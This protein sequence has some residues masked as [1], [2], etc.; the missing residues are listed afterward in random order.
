MSKKRFKLCLYLL[1]GFF[2]LTQF[3]PPV[4]SLTIEEKKAS[5]L[6]E[7]DQKELHFFLV[8]LNKNLRNLKEQLQEKYELVNQY[9][10]DQESDEA[11]QILLKEVNE[12]RFEMIDLEKKW[13]DL[14][15]SEGKNDDEGYALWDQDEISLSHLVMEYGSSDYLYVIPPEMITMKL[16]MHS[17]LPIPRES[18]SELLE[19]ILLQSGIGIKQLGPFTR[20]LY[21]LK[22]DLIA[23]DRIISKKADLVK[24]PNK[25]RVVYIFS[26]LPERIGGVCQFFERFRDPKT[27]FV[28]QV[29][30]KIAMISTKEEVEKLL[31]LHDAVWEKE[32]QKVTKVVPLKRISSMEMEQIVK[33]Y[34]GNHTQAPRISLNKG[35][36]EDL[37]LIPLKSEASLAFIGLKDVVERAEKLVKEIE[38]QVE[39]PKEMVVY[40]YTCRHSD[41]FDIAEVL[42]KIYLSL[43]Y[44]KAEGEGEVKSE[45]LEKN[46]SAKP[47]QDP[48]PQL[49]PPTYGPPPY[50]PVVQPLT[51]VAA[52]IESQKEKSLAV[53]FIPY[54][55]TGAIMMVV[56]RDTLGK[57]KELIKHLDVPKK[58]VQI[59]VLLFEKRISNKNNFGLNIL[60]L[61]SAATQTRS[62]GLSYSNN[63]D[64]GVK[65]GIV[66]F[67]I[68][69][70]KANQFWPSFDIA[71]NFLMS[72]EDVCINAA[73]SVTTLNQTPAQISLVQEISIDNG[74]APIDGNTGVV[75]QTSF[76]RAQY[77]TTLVIT[78]T[79]HEKEDLDGA[80]HSVTLDTNITF[81]TIKKTTLKADRPQVSRR[82]IEN[83]VRVIDGET[84]IL[85]GLRE[86]TAED[87]SSKLPF[88]GEIPGLGKFFGESQ[89]RDE[90]TE[91]F[92]FI[93][94][95]I[96]FESKGE[97][98]QLRK[99]ELLKRPGDLPEF[100]E[101]INEAKKRKKERLFNNSLKLMF[102]KVDG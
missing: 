18:W 12:I 22:Q 28:Y 6:L 56:R 21:L 87:S 93:T 59:E 26:P 88:L 11:Y 46:S 20:Q 14:A 58:M 79:I 99:N 82:H 86:K 54:P 2:A 98:D 55:K 40:W 70:K 57:I 101:K 31:T 85:G 64:A 96:V 37:I 77:G 36:G 73:P 68:F 25:A 69:R 89:M 92:V 80:K 63:L 84:V 3:K 34:F 76:S 61:G 60:K 49:S 78:P 75:F 48:A 27:T 9:H 1:I 45:L 7:K 42:E 100:L 15:I 32:N 81:D 10:Q 71:Y 16:H 4:F 91:M 8:D 19:I 44:S 97:F 52:T 23:V 39:D 5:L 62:T 51:A 50:S 47:I 67:F 72:Q 90:K 66:D 35:E 74:A 95:K 24:V 38:G 41:P 33:S 30:Y 13:R 65:R 29:G 17:S 43:I 94:P 102:G 53:N 83:Q